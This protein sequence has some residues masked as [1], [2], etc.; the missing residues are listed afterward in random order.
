[1]TA[2]ALR[3]PVACRHNVV[4]DVC[5]PCTLESGGE[6]LTVVCWRWKPRANYR[7]SYGPETVNTLQRMVA[8]HYPRPHRFICVTDDPA[9]I[10]AAVEVLPLWND[11]ADL[12]S[13]HG[14]N[15][16]SCYR[17]LRAFAP[18]IAAAFGPRFVSLDLDCVI[19]ND[20]RP[21]WDRVEDFVIWGD[22]NPKTHYNGSMFLMTAGARAQV[23]NTFE[24]RVSPRL[25]MAAGCFGSDQGW[26]SH[27]LGGGE[28]KWNKHDGV[29]SFRNDLQRTREL[30]AN[31]RIVFFHGRH[32]PWG[33]FAKNFPWI[34][35]H[36]R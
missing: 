15:N 23:W 33:P 21:L 32:D 10:D 35:E 34:A 28:R 24:P 6:Q 30:P 36:Y 9:G 17:R 16:P 26:I 31:A 3:Q 18:D 12:P 29:Y 19:T 5:W 14:G 1:M 20:L 13:P 4:D 11:F 27:C 8:R 25:A 7:S 2:M 22:T